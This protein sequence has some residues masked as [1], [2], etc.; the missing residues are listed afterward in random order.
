MITDVYHSN[1]L[2]DYH[3]SIDLSVSK[4]HLVPS[5]DIFER[6]R[7]FLFLSQD[8][9]LHALSQKP[10]IQRSFSIDQSLL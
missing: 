3:H 9:C 1:L 10:S 6:L 5:Q 8:V 2:A 7:K 4:I